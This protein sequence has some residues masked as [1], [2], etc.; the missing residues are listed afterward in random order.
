MEGSSLII[1]SLIFLQRI[2]L[3]FWRDSEILA[4]GR[5]EISAGRVK[6]LFRSA[7]HGGWRARSVENAGDMPP[8]VVSLLIWGLMMNMN[9][10]KQDLDVL[11]EAVEVWEKEDKGP[12]IMG[13]LLGGMLGDKSPE[14]AARFEI[15]IKA[16]QDKADRER[17]Q[18]KE[19][20]VMLRAKLITLRDQE[21]ASQFVDS[22]NG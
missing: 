16:K 17:Q 12:G 18:R 20:G 8:G 7:A 15:E 1:A 5:S 9:F 10:T 6:E 11:F 14:S 13:A 4:L 3:C 19:R 21:M 22:I 2:L